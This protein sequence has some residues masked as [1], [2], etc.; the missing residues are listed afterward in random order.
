MKN[1]MA[2]AAHD[3]NR[4]VSMLGV[5]NTDGASPTRI[6]SDPTTHEILVSDGTTGSDLGA[7]NAARDNSGVP[8]LMAVSSVDGVTPVPLYVNSSGQL[9]IK[10]T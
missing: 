2:E 5:L 4:V 8:V 6:K 7:D 1:K 10:S 9:L 3:D